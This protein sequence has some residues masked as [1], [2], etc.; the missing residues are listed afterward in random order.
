MARLDSIR[1]YFVT[2]GRRENAPIP[3]GRRRQLIVL[4]AALELEWSVRGL[5][6][7]T[8][9]G[10]YAGGLT[11]RIEKARR[12]L[13]ALG[14]TVALPEIDAMLAAAEGLRLAPGN[15]AELGYA[16]DR[17][18]AAARQFVAGHDGSRLAALD[19]FAR[20]DGDEEAAAGSDGGGG[21][22]EAGVDAG[23]E[24]GT[25]GGGGAGGGA[26]GNAGGGR[27][28]TGGGGPAA[29]RGAPA[30]PTP[31]GEVHAHLRPPLSSRPVVG[32]GRCD[33]C[34]NRE[35]DW[36]FRDPHQRTAE[37]FFNRERRNAQIATLYYGKPAAA[38]MASGRAVCMDC[39]GTVKTGR[40]GAAADSGVS[41]ES[42]HGPAG[43]FL[44]PHPKADRAGRLQLGLV[45]LRDPGVR[46]RVCSSCHYVNDARLLASG[47]PV[48][49]S[50][51]LADRSQK[52]AHWQIA[53]PDPE[54]LRSAW[55]KA[56]ADR[57]GVPAVRVVALPAGGGGGGGDGSI[58]A[59]DGAGP[60]GGGGTS[61]RANADGGDAIRYVPP[62]VTR[63][64]ERSAI[65]P[66]TPVAGAVGLPAAPDDL[67]GRPLDELLW[68]VQ[69]R[70]DALFAQVGG[71]G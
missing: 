13:A 32:Q 18:A 51:D 2:S 16:A 55:A 3:A 33:A 58:G 7:A 71:K 4:G 43:D 24:G 6:A 29:A 34:H 52:I 45:D 28:A 48:G 44:Q 57:G 17:V 62:P 22:E 10:S 59:A 67:A 70:L 21:P 60:G 23:L 26:A 39:H 15:A 68:T 46:A 20:G 42:C 19:A 65:P 38:L 36:W 37:P 27:A 61:T 69:R 11:R 14:R 41:C 66:V 40:E 56:V 1:H 63:P 8:T 5:A 12:K 47:H 25:G 53:Q 9:D 35:N 54:R 49:K 64:G 50:F 31:A 30:I